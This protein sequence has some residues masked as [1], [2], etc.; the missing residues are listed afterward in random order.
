M[1]ATIIGQVAVKVLPDTS[2]I[3][4]QTR[5]A[6]NEAE[7][8]LPNLMVEFSADVSQLV[9]Q[10]RDA[11]RRAQKEAGP[12]KVEI[13]LSEL[14]KKQ[15]Q[16][17]LAVLARN[18]RSLIKPE[19]DPGAAAKAATTLAALSGARTLGNIGTDLGEWVQDLDKALPK[20]A[21][22]SVAVADLGSGLLAGTSNALA[23]GSSLAS[24]APAALALPGILG[25]TAIGMGA[26]VAVLKDFNTVLP[27]VG[28]RFHDLQDQMSDRFWAKAK[29]PIRG[30]IDELFPQFQAGINQTSSALGSFFGNLADSA[31]GQ[32]DGEL[33]SMFDDL[34]QSIRV[35]GRYSDDFLGIIEK[36]GSVGA[37]NLPKLARYVGEV[38]DSFDN[39]LAGKGQSGLQ[40]YV[41]TGIDALK[42]LGGTLAATGS[43]FAG[44]ARAAE[45]AGGSTLAVV[46]DTMEGAADVVNGSTFQ[47]EFTNVFLNAHE[48]IRQI[49]DEAGPNLEGFLVR[50]S[51]TFSD[52]LP[53]AGRATGK[54]LGGIFGALDQPNVQRSVERVFS[55]IET[56]V[57]NIAPS[58]PSVANGLAGIAD[59]A[60]TIGINVSRGLGPALASL[61][62]A[63]AGLND[64][65]EPLARTLGDLLEGA[66]RG[67][68]PV[69]ENLAGSVGVLADTTNA[70]LKPV[71][72]LVEGIGLLPGPAQQV[73]G[74]L[75][76]IGVT[77]GAAAWL[78]PAVQTKVN[79]LATGILNAGAAV[80][81]ADDLFLNT[82][83]SVERFAGRI[84]AGK[85]AVAGMGISVVS[86]GQ[87]M[88]STNQ[89][90]GE[91][92]TV[93][94]G[95]TSGAAL[96]SAFGPLGTA[97]G[98]VAGA[99]PGV[100]QGIKRSEAAMEPA[101][102]K[103]SDYA[104]SLDQISGAATRATRALVFQD[105]QQ[106]N[107]LASGQA[108]GLSARDL[109][110]SVLGQEGALKRVNAALQ[111]QFDRRNLLSDGTGYIET[112]D[113]QIAA[114]LALAK[115]LGITTD[116][117][118]DDSA[119]VRDQSAAVSSLSDLYAG[120]DNKKIIK[121]IRTEGVPATKRE[122]A[123]L[124]SGID[125]VSRKDIRI[126]LRKNPSIHATTDEIIDLIE[127]LND[128]D[129]KH[130]KPD[131][132]I[133][134][135]PFTRGFTQAQLDVLGWGS[136][137]PVPDLRVDG[138]PVGPGVAAAQRAVDN[139]HGKEVI[140]S[141]V[142]KFV[143][144]LPGNGGPREPAPGVPAARMVANAAQK[145]AARVSLAFFKALDNQITQLRN[146]AAQALKGASDAEK[147]AIKAR[148]S[149]VIALSKQYDK[150]MTQYTKMR[151]ALKQLTQEAKAYQEQ[152][153]QSIIATGDPTRDGADSYDA[154]KNIMQI[155]ADEATKFADVMAQLK[156]KLNAET[157]AMLVDKGPEAALGAAQAILASGAGGIAALNAI[158]AQIDKAA[159]SLGLDAKDS[160]FGQQ[161]KDATKDLE[162]LAGVISPIEKKLRERIRNLMATLASEIKK[163]SKKVGRAIADV[164]E[165]PNGA[166]RTG[167]SVAVP[168]TADGNGTS[169]SVTNVNTLNYYAA[170]GPSLSSEEQL[171]KAARRGRTVFL[172]D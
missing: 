5:R 9:D 51:H 92:F 172:N 133:N 31:T 59:V 114:A 46:R 108:L 163:G 4:E 93:L 158:Q 73:L 111:E 20:M 161:I 148:L 149:S 151:D 54:A 75:T 12:I 112:Q 19:V 126:L 58:L 150:Q 109:V 157:Y 74:S 166:Q 113:R 140:L 86:L 154:I 21:A 50:L 57:D 48:A 119:A 171:F 15:L 144:L 79:G 160:K 168:S 91:F 61:G 52:V 167:R 121:E 33:Q 131:L 34:N 98:A 89:T 66:V 90:A 36:L 70:A 69:V 65:I 8:T 124:L 134:T 28:Q 37:G 97:I 128:V 105:L 116:K 139:F 146:K 53:T 67:A 1:S 27:E 122:L 62:D 77:A 155:A 76:S 55:S 10:V 135:K 22:M 11:V 101:A 129:K 6:I 25:G 43:L 162:H 170:N 63:A 44:L 78:G 94:G 127:K 145:E 35:A 47:R 71:Q 99:L 41:D 68:A 45:R 23:F 138:G 60:S 141:V 16:A 147:Q 102:V 85:L 82:A 42:D 130:P 56:A 40:D 14:D 29:E 117:F 3:R 137:F 88:M 132:D 136:N 103:A 64:D 84:T 49:S 100:I 106:N 169:S 152:V 142:R 95:A 96:G 110:G 125:D 7:A 87:Q 123:E 83:A 143:D 164:P 120:L 153:Y 104:S 32:F 26:T 2:E 72:L 81:K 17:E 159:T 39:W 18:R 165:T 118:K 107:V 30:F 80:G 156:G 115:V 38:A 13:E 24:I